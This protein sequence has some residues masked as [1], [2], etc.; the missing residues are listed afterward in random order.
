VGLAG[1]LVNPGSEAE[2]SPVA[3]DLEQNQPST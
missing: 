2:Q 3:A 1:V